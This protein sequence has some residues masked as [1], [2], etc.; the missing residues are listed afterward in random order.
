M[1][2]KVRN[3]LDQVTN[4]DETP[5]GFDDGLTF[6]KSEQEKLVSKHNRDQQLE[7]NIL[8][9][10]SRLARNKNPFNSSRP[11]VEEAFQ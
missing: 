5:N 10:N 4:N 3:N 2:Q 11:T 8:Q 1:R 6:L 7:M 9:N